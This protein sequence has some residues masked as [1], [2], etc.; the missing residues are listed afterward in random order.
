MNH[1]TNPHDPHAEGTITQLLISA[2]DGDEQAAIELWN[3]Y[4]HRLA[5]VAR[6]KLRG[7]PTRA[8]DEEDAV[9]SAFGNMLEG[10][11]ANRFA[12]LE[13]RD[14]LWQVLV[15]LTARKSI[16]HRRRAEAQKRGGG[17]VRGESVFDQQFD[18]SDV[19]LGIAAIIA[20]EPT[21]D[22]LA[23]MEEQCQQLLNVLDD[24]LRTVA[25]LRLEGYLNREIAEKTEHTISWVERKLRLIRTAWSS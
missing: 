14:D 2:K 11:K 19:A 21:P 8:S 12:Q 20:E 9:L 10:I 3:A 4:F 5:A 16:E 6:R 23:E 17:Q 22:F 7:A 25:L 13:D 1:S 15:M 18:D 24:D